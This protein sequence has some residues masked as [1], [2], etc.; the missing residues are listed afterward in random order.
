MS[1]EVQFIGRLG[2]HLFQYAVGRL[3]AEDLG[4]HLHCASSEFIQPQ[5]FGAPLDCGPAAALDSLAPFFPN[6][7]LQTPGARHF[8]PVERIEVGLG[9]WRGQKLDLGTILADKSPRQIRLKGW[10]QRWEYYRNRQEDIRHWFTPTLACA[11]RDVEARDVLVSIRRGAD[12][13]LSGW[14]VPMDYYEQAL[15]SLSRVGRVFVCGTGV[16]QIV[17][18]RLARFCPIYV[19]GTPIT[20]FALAKRFRRIVLSNSTF[21]WWAA[22]LSDAPEIVAPQFTSGRAYCF[23]GF[24]D[25]DLAL[26]S[27]GYRE[28]EIDRPAPFTL[29][30]RGPRPAVGAGA[31][32]DELIERLCGPIQAGDLRQSLLGGD[33][34]NALREMVL[35]GLLRLNPHYLESLD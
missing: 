13:G 30:E 25:V 5:I 4:F 15:S 14:T 7:P 6:A 18:S 21:A 29:F 34:A 12:Y 32:E 27:P 11:A 20:H 22:F 2:N 3:I 26:P 10:F 28:I 19:D 31:L 16:D 17:R 9:G 33:P 23:R 1:V 8:S 35:S 24:E